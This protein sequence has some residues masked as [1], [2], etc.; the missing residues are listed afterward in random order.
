MVTAVRVMG[1]SFV[2]VGVGGE[3]SGACGTGAARRGAR[4]RAGEFAAGEHG[5]ARDHDVVDADGER[6]GLRIGGAVGDRVGVVQAVALGGQSGEAADRLGPAERPDLARVRAE[7]ARES[8][9]PRGCGA[10]PM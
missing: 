2:R 7:Q 8:A 4:S 1:V 3:R 9:Q 6:G 5:H 10:S